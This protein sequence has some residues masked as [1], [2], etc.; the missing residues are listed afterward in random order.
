MLSEHELMVVQM[1]PE[2]AE[3]AK[4]LALFGMA[5]A[6][7]NTIALV[8]AGVFLLASWRW[9]FRFIVSLEAH[10]LGLELTYRRSSLHPLLSSL[11]S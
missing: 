8:L 10:Y 11:G 1:Y 9:Y 4:K 3:Q 5:G 6:L 2:P 7:A